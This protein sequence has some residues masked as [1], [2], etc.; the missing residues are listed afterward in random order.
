MKECFSRIPKRAWSILVS[1]DSGFF[2]G[3]LLDL[4]EEKARAVPDQGQDEESGPLAY[5]AVMAQSKKQAR[6]RDHGIHV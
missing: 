6:P 3:A 4:L 1:A 5:G 2:N